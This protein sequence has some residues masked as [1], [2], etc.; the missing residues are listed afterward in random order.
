[1][2]SQVPSA[3]QESYQETVRRTV[4]LIQEHEYGSQKVR[5]IFEN[6]EP[7]EFWAEFGLSSPGSYAKAPEWNREAID[8]SRTSLN[9]IINCCSWSTRGRRRRA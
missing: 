5:A 8:V 1:M 9:L 2:G 4:K 7:Q 3:N 6:E